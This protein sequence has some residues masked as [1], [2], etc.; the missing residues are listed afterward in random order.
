MIDPFQYIVD[1]HF[2]GKYLGL[3]F[4]P[5][6]EQDGDGWGAPFQSGDPLTDIDPPFGT[7]LT[8]TDTHDKRH[9]IAKLGLST[10]TQQFGVQH[11]EASIATH[12]GNNYWSSKISTD[13]NYSNTDIVSWWGIPGNGVD[14]T[15]KSV[16]LPI[17]CG[18]ISV[19]DVVCIIGSDTY[20]NVITGR[21][22][23]ANCAG[24]T[25]PNLLTQAQLEDAWNVVSLPSLSDHV[26]VNGVKVDLQGVTTGTYGAIITGACVFQGWLIYNTVAMWE[27][28]GTTKPD[29]VH[30]IKL[31]TLEYKFLDDY[32]TDDFTVWWDG[33]GYYGVKR[34]VY[35]Q[36][37]SK[38]ITSRTTTDAPSYYNQAD[39][40]KT[41]GVITMGGDGKPA[42]TVTTSSTIDNPG[43]YNYGYNDNIE[44]YDLP[45]HFS[46]TSLLFTHV[47]HSNPQYDFICG[48]MT[49]K[50]TCSTSALTYSIYFFVQYDG[51]VYRYPIDINTGLPD[52]TQVSS[53]GNDITDFSSNEIDAGSNYSAIAWEGG[54][55]LSMGSINNWGDYWTENTPGDTPP[56]CS[57]NTVYPYHN[58]NVWIKPDGSVVDLG[59]TLLS[60][61]VNGEDLSIRPMTL[62]MIT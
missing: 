59:E 30:A 34:V 46:G 22:A 44:V 16:A 43:A 17:N 28:K 7:E 53:S 21:T 4:S 24:G 25:H 12:Q 50:I 35:S 11:E 8:N 38:S 49:E 39:S 23:S 3:F 48:Y 62:Q 31:D 57:H 5:V 42:I 1:C 58:A 47:T 18:G 36:D 10:I 33:N 13:S 27:D 40:R 6:F 14:H 2:G 45:V 51:D 55:L 52:F 41:T 15:E 54:V 32:P 19:G 61:T 20:W 29:E 60:N 37:G 9:K 26:F 56:D